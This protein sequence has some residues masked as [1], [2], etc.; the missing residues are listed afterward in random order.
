MSRSLQKQRKPLALEKIP[1]A[2]IA[3]E[4][5]VLSCYKQL[6]EFLDEHNLP[7]TVVPNVVSSARSM[8][9]ALEHIRAALSLADDLN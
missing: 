7:P 2:L 8:K 4:Q 6:R 5:S 1:P 3:H 9:V